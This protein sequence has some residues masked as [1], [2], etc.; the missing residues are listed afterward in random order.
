MIEVQTIGAVA[1]TAVHVVAWGTVV[2]Y[3]TGPGLDNGGA[4]IISDLAQT[5][6]FIANISAFM[7]R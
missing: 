6:P 2:D 7:N 5:G 3:S 4:A 1:Q